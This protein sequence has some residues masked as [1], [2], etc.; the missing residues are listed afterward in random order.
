M[1][2]VQCAADVVLDTCGTGG[3]SKGTFN[4]STAGAFVIAGAGITVAKHG[5]RSVSSACA[6]PM[7]WK[8]RV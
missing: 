8:R 4:I 1:V 6:A 7:F 3:D 2:K 5:N